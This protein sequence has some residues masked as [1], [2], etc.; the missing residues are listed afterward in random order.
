M[1]RI[2]GGGEYCWIRTLGRCEMLGVV[3]IGLLLLFFFIFFF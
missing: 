3:W 2:G 1:S